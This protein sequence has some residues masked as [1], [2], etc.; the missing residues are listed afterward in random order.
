M[1]RTLLLLLIG[2]LFA[3]LAWTVHEPDAAEQ[4]IGES[5]RIQKLMD[6]GAVALDHSAGSELTNL[7]RTGADEWMRDRTAPLAQERERNGTIYFGLYK[8]SLIC[9]TGAPPMEPRLFR[10]EMGRHLKLFNGLYI[11]ASARE[12]D[13]ELHALRPVWSTPPMEN[14]YMQSGFHPSLNAPNGLFAMLL[15][16]EGPEVKDAA[17]KTMFRVAWR[18]GALE[19]GNWVWIRLLLASMAIAFSISALWHWSMQRVISGYRWSGIFLFGGILVAVRLLYLYWAPDSPLNR[20]VFFDPALYAASARF[21]SLGDLF[22][23]ASLLALIAAFVRTAL[24]RSASSIIRPAHVVIGFSISLIHAA[25]V[26][27][28]FIGL[29]NDSSVDLD[30]YHVQELSSI[31]ALAL[32]SIALLFGS[33]VLLTSAILEQ[34]IPNAPVRTVAIAG[35]LILGLS[36]LVHHV[37][38]VYDTLL[39]LWPVPLFFVLLWGI[40]RTPGFGKVLLGVALVAGISA[41]V[42]TKYTRNREHRERQVLA[43]RLAVRED[44]VVELMFRELA[45]RLREADDLYGMLSGLS[46]C[47]SVELDQR[48]RQRFFNGYWERYDVRLFAFGP[49]GQALCA[50]DPDPPKSFGSSQSAFTLPTVAVDMPDLF[51]QEQPGQT[52][53]Y[54]ARVAVMPNDSAAP[55]QLVIELHPRSATQGLGFPDLLLGGDDPLMRRADRYAVARYENSELVDRSG[56]TPYSLHWDRKL[57]EDGLLWYA[58]D[59][60][61]QLAIGD[62]NGTLL[63]LGLLE[64]DLTDQATTFSYLFALFSILVALVF[65]L[66]TMIRSNGIPPM[67]IGAKVRVALGFFALVGLVYF[68]VGTQRLLTRQYIQRFEAM[69]MEKARSVHAELQQKF[70]GET[71]LNG[72]HAAYLDHLLSR[73]SNVFFTDITLYDVHGSLLATSRPQ[74]FAAGLLGKKMDPDA[75][76]NVVLNNASSFVQE[77][78]IGNAKFLSAY[79]PLRDR[80]GL[81]L[82]YIALPSFADQAQQEVERNGVLVAVVNLFVLLFALSVL[83]AVFISNWTTRPLDLLKRSLSAVALGGTNRPIRYRGQ[84]EVGQLVEVYNRKVD[85]LRESAEKLARSERETAWREM[86]QQVAHEIKKPLTPMKL[87]I[88]HFQRTWAPDAPDAEAKL[89]RFSTGMVQQIEVLSGI[90][91]AFGDF[92]R[93]PRAKPEDLDLGEVAEMALSVFNGTPNVHFELER[94]T[95]DPL[96]IHADREQLLHVFNNL[97]KNAMQAVPDERV[98]HIS[99]T[100][101]REKTLAVAEVKDNGVGIEEADRERIFQPNF[102]TKSSGMGLGLA[103]VL[104]IVEAAGGTVTFTTNV[105]VGTTFV[106]K[107]PLR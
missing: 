78:A 54:H 77:E 7:V 63:V 40:G 80:N 66:D 55:A 1:R 18:D 75:Y 53:F 83:V 12:G 4:A 56:A 48:V 42:L 98:A 73:A 28:L 22:I 16:T 49:D 104:R 47:G 29:V 38:G 50:T 88:Q 41:H 26:T 14:R 45:P 59:G 105:G 87:S 100:L 39:F 11:H 37:I 67:G 19:M 21:P 57:D 13:L 101:R 46:P 76:R 5:H 35:S 94:N 51:M 52:A 102:T 86:A 60:Y 70:V 24:R 61:E 107:L 93:M 91:N 2:F 20:L 31:S 9:W 92:A 33:W 44:P 82:A 8:D 25:W 71:V 17:G 74:I 69:I 81:V 97:L 90:A 15:G 58:D 96:L 23:N 64:P 99:V 85:E 106:L 30:L 103:M 79:M 34:I 27:H 36:T 32:L 43:E 10:G 62:P 65:L 3:V 95:A 72:D 6:Q 84:D 68:G 89:D